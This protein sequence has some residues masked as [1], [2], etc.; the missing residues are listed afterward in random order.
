MFEDYGPA[1]RLMVLPAAIIVEGVLAQLPAAHMP[2][3]RDQRRWE[4]T[5][6]HGRCRHRG[7]VATFRF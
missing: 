6:P 5:G 7:Y 2:R 4:G 3:M 1:S